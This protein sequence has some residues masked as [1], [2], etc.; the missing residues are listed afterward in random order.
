MKHAEIIK[1]IIM[2]GRDTLNEAQARQLLEDFGIPV[3]D[4]Q[5]F[6]SID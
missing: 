1:Q 4:A 3:V 2:E 5:I 6:A